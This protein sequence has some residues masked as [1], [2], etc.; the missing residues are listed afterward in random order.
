MNTLLYKNLLL[1]SSLLVSS[2]AFSSLSYAQTEENE[3]AEVETVDTE[4]ETAE[5]TGDTVVVTGSRIK[6]DTFSSISPIQTITTELSRDIGLID[7]GQ[8]LQQ[9]E[10]AAGQQVDS[11]F[12]G[13]VTANG[14]GSETVNLRGLGANRTLLLLNGRRLAPIGAEGAP[15][16]PSINLLPSTLVD[17][18]D[19]L[20]DGASSVYG[21]DAVAGVANLILR[22]DFEGLELEFFGDLNE[23]GAGN[24]YTISAAYGKNND[25]GFIGFGAEYDYQ[26]MVNIDDRDYFQPCETN[27]EIDENGQIRTESRVRQD[28][29]GQIGL[30]YATEPCQLQGLGRRIRRVPGGLGFVY[31][32]PGTTNVGIPNFSEDTQFS[33]PIDGDGDGN[34]DVYLPDYSPNGAFNDTTFINEQKRISLMSYGEYVMEGEMN[35]TPYFEALFTKV[36]VFQDSGASQLFTVVPASN[37][38]NPCN[39][40]QPNGVDCG[41]AADSLLTNPNYINNFRDYY[42][43]GPG[44][45]NCFGLAPADCT[46]ANFG[47]L[48][49]PLGPQRAGGGVVV[50]GDRDITEVTLEQ[51]RGVVGFKGDLPQLSFGDVKDWSFDASFS[52]S[53]SKGTSRRPGVRDDRLHF[54]LGFDPNIRNAT[55]QLVDLAGGPCVADPGSPV[56]ADIADGCVPINLFAPSLY[57]NVIGDF[58]TQAERDYVF[59]DRDFDTE[60]TQATF[61]AFVTGKILSLPAGD[62]GLVLGMEHRHDEINSIPDNVARDG[63]FFGFFSDQGATGEKSTSEVFGEIDI[64]LVRDKAFF[65]DLEVNGSARWTEDEFYG[66]AWTYAGKAGWRPF[67]SLLLKTSYGT[68]FRA[69]NL[70]E[71]FLLGTTG[72]PNVNDPC[73][74]PAAAVGVG[75]GYNAA[76]DP[77][78]AITLANCAADPTGLDPTNFSPI[79]GNASV[80]SA[81]SRTGG[82]QDLEEETST[83]LTVG[84]AFEQP[85]TDWIDVSL[86]INYFEIDVRNTVVT[87]TSQFI[88]NDCYINQP[89]RSS[90][91]C[92][93]I[94]RSPLN[95]SANPGSFSLIDAGFLNQDREKVTGM[96]FNLNL[97]KDVIVFDKIVDLGADFRA[98]QLTERSSLFV[99]DLGNSNFDDVVGEFGFPEWAGRMRLTADYGDWRLTWQTRFIDSVEQDPTLIDPFSD[100]TDSQ[101]TGFRG[102]TCGGPTLGDVLCRDVGFAKSQFLHTASV[103]YTAGTWTVVGGV[104]NI[105]DKA[106]PLVDPNEVLSV[107]NVAI[108]SGYDYDGREFFLNVRKTF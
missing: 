84:L 91:F 88:I 48:N 34:V 51:F 33:V 27:Y 23:Q 61:S 25:R 16:A 63:L 8:L 12:A 31:Y 108:G 101:G 78:D 74:T 47:L 50:Q 10:S 19:L 89:N 36:D 104:S 39:P 106:P 96:D 86:N 64:P 37:P 66:S 13:L 24:D 30:N 68:S 60:Y 11:T 41:L 53:K 62:V 70:R 99:D 6:R 85:F 75:G 49:G 45:A 44:S 105:F 107:N 38:F 7:P 22:K 32:T 15:F 73:V 82:A 42:S 103:R 58:A 69:P 59:D 29:Y 77:R 83:S 43:G 26:D 3:P 93:R 21:S 1:G 57:D 9:D 35:V 87:P 95:A 76:L 54:A 100:T 79:P 65:R 80:Y 14:P 56:S 92:S 94:Q 97:G 46:P 102:D 72:F 52:F 67:D 98:T 4:D 55:N 71:N 5:E 81:E 28:L 20:L 2:F 18:T 90:A 17:R 40:G